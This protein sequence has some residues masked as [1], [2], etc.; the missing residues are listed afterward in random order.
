MEWIL[1]QL[2]MRLIHLCYINTET[3]RFVKS[4][5]EKALTT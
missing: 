1:S 2:W 4:V 5:K 3:T